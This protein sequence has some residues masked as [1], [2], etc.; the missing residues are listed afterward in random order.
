M[1]VL[2]LGQPILNLHESLSSIPHSRVI[3]II[4]NV[5]HNGQ[6]NMS[7]WP[8]FKMIFDLHLSSLQSANIRTLGKY[9][10]R[11]LNFRASFFHLNFEYGDG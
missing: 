9:V 1:R 5:L 11:M 7:L 3:L 2:T 8:H 4:F 10:V 6:D